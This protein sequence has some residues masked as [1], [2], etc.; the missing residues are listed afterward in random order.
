ME[1]DID[2]IDALDTVG[3]VSTAAIVIATTISPGPATTLAE[4]PWGERLLLTGV[5]ER[6]ADLEAVVVVVRDDASAEMVE[7]AP[8]VVVI[9]DP[10]WEEGDAAPVRAGLDWL[11]RAAD[12]EA[13]FVVTLDA[14]EIE[15]KVLIEL[16]KAHAASETLITVP[17]YRY[18]RGGPVLLGKDI[19]PRFLGAEGE[20]NVEQLILAHPQWVNEAR[21]DSAPPRRILTADDLLEL[22]K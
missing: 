10:E 13:V 15:P 14:P 3:P 18:V 1:F 8:N 5:V 20:L 4:E 17:K 6:L 11:T 16:A 7:P 12:V 9:I 22:S 21:V 19:W 2:A